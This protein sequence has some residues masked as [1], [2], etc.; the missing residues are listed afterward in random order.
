MDVLTSRLRPGLSPGVMYRNVR[1]TLG[2][3]DVTP[4]QIALM[5]VALGLGALYVSDVWL[6][7]AIDD[8]VLLDQLQA[9]KGGVEVLATGGFVY[10]LTRR[11]RRALHRTNEELERQQAELEILHRVLRH[12]LRN[13]INLVAGYGASLAESLGESGRTKCEALLAAANRIVRYAEKTRQIHK[14]TQTDCRRTIDLVDVL[15]SL[16]EEEAQRRDS[17][18]VEFSAPD[19]APVRAHPMLETA[20]EELVQNAI[21]HHD[22]THPTV[23]VSVDPRA[24][25]PGWTEIAVRDDGPGVPDHV[26][27]TIQ[28]RGES[29]LLH[30]DGLGMWLVAWVVDQSEG[31]FSI[32][33]RRPRGTIVRIRLLSAPDPSP[34]IPLLSRLFRRGGGISW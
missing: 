12:N 11:S 6:V 27:H 24:G 34:S 28:E 31:E 10:V 21:Q 8:P 14:V 15:G 7:R 18:T 13:D 32:E 17:G 16:I 22:G 20:V 33:D 25:G 30:L 3:M 4:A 23:T 5:Y 9:A 29:Q 2:E 1:R 19:A 26:R